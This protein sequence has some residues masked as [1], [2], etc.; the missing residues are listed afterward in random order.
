MKRA[1]T[2]GR[3]ASLTKLCGF[4][5]KLA[6]VL[7]LAFLVLGASGYFH[8]AAAA[9]INFLS[10]QLNPIQE[11]EFVRNEILRPFTQAT[12]HSVQFLPEQSIIDRVLAEVQ[13][14]RVTI[15]V[16]GALHG[17]FPMLAARNALEPLT[18]LD[19]L[20]DRTFVP[21]FLRL[22]EIDGQ[23]VYAPWLQ[24]TYLMMANE[25]ALQYL[26]EGA[27]INALTYDE[28]LQWAKNLYEET[29]GPKLGFPQG[30]NGL[31]GR[32]VHGYLYPSFTGAQVSAFDS[33]EAVAMWE[34]LIELNQYVHPSSQIWDGMADPLLFEEVWVAWDHTARLAPALNERPDAFVVFP[35]PAG[36][37]GRGFITV[38]AGLGIPR[39]YADLDAAY[40]L[41]DHLTRPETQVK[42]LEGTGFFP[43][44]TEAA[45]HLPTGPQRKLAE[46]VT[47]QASA[48]DAIVALLPVGLGERTGEYVPIF[49]DTYQAIVIEGAPIAEVLQR[50]NQL[51]Q[52]LY[53]ETG[54]PL[55]D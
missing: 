17:D 4:H 52:A 6:G 7:A 41:I 23:Q 36:P 9:S 51:L 40:A 30:P 18:R 38:L 32:M 34:Y 42:V 44:V 45:G 2:S 5:L 27:D 22:G 13:A 21:E 12:G 15:G 33:P 31:F 28:L 55:P 54:A 37:K 25:K 24:A 10:T 39:G 1:A 46:A 49:R 8:H 26:P 19:E 20:T 48:P 3:I 29:G 11:A 47:L 14:G 43:T 50:Q 53:R 16:I 35:A